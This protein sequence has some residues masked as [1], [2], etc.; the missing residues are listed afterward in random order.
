MKVTQY[1][2]NKQQKLSP[3]RRLIA[4]A[5]IGGGWTINDRCLSLTE[6]LAVRLCNGEVVDAV[7]VLQA[8]GVLPGEA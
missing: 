3:N 8:V 5:F 4:T 1:R 2:R 6:R 7:L